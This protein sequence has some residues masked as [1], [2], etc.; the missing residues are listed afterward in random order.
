VVGVSIRCTVSNAA[1]SYSEPLAVVPKLLPTVPTHVHAWLALFVQD[2][3][4]FAPIFT[5]VIDA[6]DVGITARRKEVDRRRSILES[7]SQSAR[8]TEGRRTKQEKTRKFHRD[9]RKGVHC[10]ALP[11][12]TIQKNEI[13]DARGLKTSSA[14]TRSTSDKFHKIMEGCKASRTKKL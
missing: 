8:N 11:T 5:H 12:E 7:F 6:K 3:V 9:S 2:A 1:S 4:A 13:H 14:N 10:G